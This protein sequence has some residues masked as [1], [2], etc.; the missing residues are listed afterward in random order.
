MKLNFLTLSRYG[1]I[2]VL[3][4]DLILLLEGHMKVGIC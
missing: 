2:Q 1:D 3:F 4:Q